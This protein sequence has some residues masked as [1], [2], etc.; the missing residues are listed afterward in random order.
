MRCHRHP[1]SRMGALLVWLAF[2]ACSDA[3]APTNSDPIRVANDAHY[4][5]WIDPDRSDQ[6]PR[7]MRLRVEPTGEWHIAPEAPATLKLETTGEASFEP[8][9]Q[10][11][12]DALSC[13]ADGIEF[14]ARVSGPRTK[15]SAGDGH[16]KF[17][18]CEGESERCII[19]RRSFP[20]PVGL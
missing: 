18:I 6:A 1:L 19:V 16:L 17:G 4:R 15:S 10:E 11:R 5:V 12:E 9:E 14:V 8:A 20:L 3:V 7:E 13:S 2:G